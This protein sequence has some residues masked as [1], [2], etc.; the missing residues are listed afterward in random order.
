MLKLD[1]FGGKRFKANW[2][3]I[4][5]EVNQNAPVNGLGIQC[6][7]T[8]AGT[9]INQAEETGDGG[10][11]PIHGGGTGGSSGTTIDV[12]GAFNGAAATYHFL[13][14]SAPTP[15]P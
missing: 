13:Q 1:K 11:S 3:K 7:V 8:P 12:T 15:I 5:A 14:S 2:E 10:D 9:Q 4:E 6:D